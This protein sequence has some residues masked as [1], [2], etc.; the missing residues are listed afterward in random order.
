MRQLKERVEFGDMEG[1]ENDKRYVT[2]KEG[3]YTLGNT[4]EKARSEWKVMKESIEQ[5]KKQ[6][7][8]ISNVAVVNQ[9]DTVFHKLDKV[10]EQEGDS[11]D[12]D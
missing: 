9:R 1:D 7:L 3:F 12:I 6:Y 5:T 4:K 11:M 10:V 2:I 8:E